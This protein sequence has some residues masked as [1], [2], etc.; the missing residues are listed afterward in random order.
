M[1]R[2]YKCDNYWFRRKIFKT[3]VSKLKSTL[4]KKVDLVGLKR[5]LPNL[6][7]AWQLEFMSIKKDKKIS[8]LQK[9]Q[10][11]ALFFMHSTC[12]LKLGSQLLLEGGDT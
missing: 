5:T 2:I 11:S 8:T 12:Y 6:L 3:H 7:F 4:K 9:I 1:I 10:V